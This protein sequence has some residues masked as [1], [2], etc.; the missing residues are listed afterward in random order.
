L[1]NITGACACGVFDAQ[2]EVGKIENKMNIAGR[3][4]LVVG[5]GKTGIATAGFLLR[6]GEKVA[7]SDSR[8]DV[9]WSEE[10]QSFREQGA[11]IELGGHT[12][13]SFDW[14]DTIVLSPGVPFTIPYVQRAVDSGKEVIS[15]IELASNFITK[16]VI[17]ITGSNG[18]TTTTTMIYNILV[19]S[20]L[21][22]FLGGNIGSPLI[23]V[24]ENDSEYDY[25]LLELS[26]FQLQGIRK[27]RPH[28]AVCLNIYPNHL[29]HH[30][31]LEEYINAKTN[32]FKNQGTGDLAVINSGDPVLKEQAEKVKSHVLKFGSGKD[33][34][35]CI[36][37][38]EIQY[39]DNTY[40]LA[41]FKLM[42]KHNME[43]AAAAIIVTRVLGCEKEI[44]TNTILQF[45][46]LPHRIEYIRDYKNAR[47][48]ND[49]KSTTPHSTLKALEAFEP[50]VILIAGGKDKGLDYSI[51]KKQITEKVK[52]LIVLG[53]A[54][55]KM[56]DIYESC[57]PLTVVD[58]LDSAV[59]QAALAAESGDTVLFSPACSSF[60][61]F[62]SYEERGRKFKE[63]VQCL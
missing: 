7:V 30:K 26:S 5:L 37:G 52:R 21:R 63:I 35:A 29:D 15:E 12:Y 43:N 9:G 28:I 1:D 8:Q 61:M 18:K 39:A 59:R 55:A 3:K 50:P 60:D 57:V 2:A 17:G 24:A 20:G 48:F 11:T 34:D 41:A 31:D 56:K 32:I 51:L 40:D 13:A 44:I 62:S 47:F 10:L 23:E 19:A 14:A 53:E 33:N 38:H 42:G 45:S 36:E 4:Y 58:S 46:S 6:K 27:F 49:S 25:L 54:S 16:P 22:V